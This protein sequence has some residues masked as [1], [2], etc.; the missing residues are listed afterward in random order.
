M[1]LKKWTLEWLASWAHITWGKF[2]KIVII[3]GNSCHCDKCVS[4]S[5]M[6]LHL[7]SKLLERLCSSWYYYSFHSLQKRKLNLYW[8]TFKLTKVLSLSKIIPFFKLSRILL[9]SFLQ[10][11]LIV[12]KPHYTYYS[13]KYSCIRF[14]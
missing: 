3:R 8:S 14:F 5:V 6:L 4:M 7:C 13:H 2:F 1:I 9:C 11:W 10:F 12:A